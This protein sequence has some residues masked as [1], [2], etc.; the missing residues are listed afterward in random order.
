MFIPEPTPATHAMNRNFGDA[1]KK[2]DDMGIATA[3]GPKPEAR[4]SFHPETI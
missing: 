3:T 4:Q 1:S 2:V